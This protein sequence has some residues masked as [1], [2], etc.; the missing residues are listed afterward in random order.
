MASRRSN[1]PGDASARSI[2]FSNTNEESQR[3]I[4][5]Q[6]EKEPEVEV[7]KQDDESTQIDSENSDHKT[8]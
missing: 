1:R 2:H 7:Q 3:V 4:Q 5:Q 6:N 8:R